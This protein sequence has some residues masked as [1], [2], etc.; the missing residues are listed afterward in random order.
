MPTVI[1]CAVKRTQE[2]KERLA[3]AIVEDV[4]NIFNVTKDH[5]MIYFE[6]RKKSDIFKGGIPATNWK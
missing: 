4:C 1:V 6:D 5:V 2:Q 3:K